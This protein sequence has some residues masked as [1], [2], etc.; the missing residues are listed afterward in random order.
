[1]SLYR[2]IHTDAFDDVSQSVR[3]CET[4]DIGFRSAEIMDVRF[5][6]DTAVMLLLKKKGMG[7]NLLFEKAA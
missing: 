6:D 7:V 1:V 4:L 3:S 2:V 5:V